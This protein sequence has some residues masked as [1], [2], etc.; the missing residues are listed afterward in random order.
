MKPL[1]MP[2]CLLYNPKKTNIKLNY[3]PRLDELNHLTVQ[4]TM[5][6]WENCLKWR[7]STLQPGNTNTTCPLCT[8][9]SCSSQIFTTQHM[10]LAKQVFCLQTSQW[11]CSSLW[12]IAF[13]VWVW[14][15]DH[16]MHSTSTRI[17]C[18]K[19]FKSWSAHWTTLAVFQ[20]AM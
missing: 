1:I 7:C 4:V 8:L 11:N 14:P 6:P 20:N 10:Q 15:T 13:S 5:S 16:E 2:P 17:L 12:I 18:T 19:S 3:H 9:I